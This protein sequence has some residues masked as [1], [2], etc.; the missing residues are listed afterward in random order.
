MSEKDIKNETDHMEVGKFYFV[1]NKYDEAVAEFK[2]V[3][4]VNPNNS[5]AYYNIGL[6]YETSNNI[7]EAKKMYSKALAINPDYKTAR[8]KLNKLIGLGD[9]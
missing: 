2:K 5:E 9:E 3:L 8:E 7:D 1:N 4:E 6:I